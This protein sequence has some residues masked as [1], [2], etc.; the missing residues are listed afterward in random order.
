M[1]A[2][3][4]VS[5]VI[6]TITAR[7]D[8]TTGALAD[9]LAPTLAAVAAQTY[10]REAIESMVVVDD[11][12]PAGAV[13]EIARRFPPV[14]LVSSRRSNYFEAKNAGAASATGELVALLDGDCA[15]SPDWLE[16]IT[17][18]LSAGADAVAGCTRYGGKS[19]AAW[20][21]SVPDFAYVIAEADGASGFNINNVIFRRE[22]LLAHPFDARIRRNGGCYFLFHQLRAAGLRVV[23]EP[24]A[25]V[26]HGL[27]IRGLG[28]LRKHFER[29]YDGVDVYRFDDRAV[30]RGTRLFRR[31]GALAL[32]PMYARRA[33]FDWLRLLRHRREIGIPLAAVPYFGAVA[34]MLR[35]VELSGALAA[36]VR[37][38]KRRGE[39]RGLAA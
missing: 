34:V 24:R 32:P 23:Y 35:I 39:E 25:I 37:T 33:A 17:A 12:V 1:T 31:L 4:R 8:S 30:L 27:D 19:F 6:E 20:T 28:F 2:A 10:P 38:P 3:P 26:A 36:M 9:D 14:R 13:A 11:E 29:G 22:V 18:R 16:V 7:F 15:P 5:V 21:F